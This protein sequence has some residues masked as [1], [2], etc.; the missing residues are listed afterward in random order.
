MQIQKG[1]T[2]D[3]LSFEKAGIPSLTIAQYPIVDENGIDLPDN[4][5]RIDKTKLKTSAL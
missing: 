1:P 4:I 2:S 3:N 5:S